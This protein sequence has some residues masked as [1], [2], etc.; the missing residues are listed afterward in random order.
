MVFSE[1]PITDHFLLAAFVCA[2][3]NTLGIDTADEAATN[4]LEPM[5]AGQMRRGRDE[6]DG[7]ESLR[8]GRNADR[9]REESLAALLCR[10]PAVDG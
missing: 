5:R 9:R 6:R 8:T 10:V 4:W 3:H 7:G 1:F 2:H